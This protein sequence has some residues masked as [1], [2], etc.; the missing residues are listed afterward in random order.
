MKKTPPC[1]V[2]IAL[3]LENKAGAVRVELQFKNDV[4]CGHTLSTRG[5]PPEATI[6][7]VDNFART[8]L[9]GQSSAECVLIWKECHEQVKAAQA[10]K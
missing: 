2:P 6:Q 10:G 3:V 5:T 8:T 9:L 1:P 4:C 7:L